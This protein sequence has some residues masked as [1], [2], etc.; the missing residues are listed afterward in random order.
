LNKNLTDMGWLGLRK[1]RYEIRLG[2]CQPSTRPNSPDSH[3]QQHV[4]RTCTKCSIHK[5]K[6][7]S[8]GKDVAYHI[9]NSQ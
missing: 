9:H 5:Q 7:L 6:K 2:F 8:F 3:P 4:H 1:T